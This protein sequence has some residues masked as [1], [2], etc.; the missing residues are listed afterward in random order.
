MSVVFGGGGYGGEYYGGDGGGYYGDGTGDIAPYEPTKQDYLNGIINTVRDFTYNTALGKTPSSSETTISAQT[1]AAIASGLVTPEEA[2]KVA[3]ETMASAAAEAAAYHAPANDS[4]KYGRESS[5]FY[6]S[7]VP[8]DLISI[9]EGVLRGYNYENAPKK[10]EAVH[11]L[12]P[13]LSEYYRTGSETALQKAQD[14]AAQ[15]ANAG[16]TQKEFEG[17]DAFAKAWTFYDAKKPGFGSFAEGIVKPL[18]TAFNVALPIVTTVISG[19]VASGF[20]LSGVAA[21]AV[22]GA[23]SGG[24]NAAIKDQDVLQGALLGGTL[25]AATGAASSAAGSAVSDAIG[26]TAGAVAGSAASGATSAGIKALLLGDNPNTPEDEGDLFKALLKGATTGGVS[27][28]VSQLG[29]EYLGDL[30]DPLKQ[31][32]VSATTAKL[33]GGNA[34]TAFINSVMSSLPQYLRD[35]ASTR[36]I[37]VK[38]Y[39]DTSRGLDL[40]PE[41]DKAFVDQLAELDVEYARQIYQEKTGDELTDKQLRDAFS[42]GNPF[43]AVDKLAATELATTTGSELDKFVKDILKDKVTLTSDDYISLLGM[44]ET[45]AKNALIGRYNTFV[46]DFNTVT[47]EEAQSIWDAAGNT[48]PMTSEEMFTMLAGNQDSADSFAKRNAEFDTEVF[49]GNNYATQEEARAAALAAKEDTGTFN[50]YRWGDRIYKTDQEI[51]YDPYVNKT[52]NSQVEAAIEAARNNKTTYVWGD[53]VFAINQDFAKAQEEINKQPTFT[54]A[55][56]KAQ[57]LL[58]S[59]KPFS[60]KDQGMFT[61]PSGVPGQ[62]GE[63]PFDA[64]DFGELEKFGQNGLALAAVEANKAGKKTFTYSDG[65]TY[66]L[67]D[68][69]A[70]LVSPDQTLAETRRLFEQNNLLKTE[71]QLRAEADF[72]AAFG[73]LAEY[74]PPGSD[75]RNLVA[76]LIGGVGNIVQGATG[77]IN[78][79]ASVK[80]GAEPTVGLS[81]PE[82][83]D[84]RKYGVN[85]SIYDSPEE[86]AAKVKH[87]QELK[88]AGA[89]PVTPSKNLALDKDSSMYKLGEWLETTGVLNSPEAQQQKQVIAD[90]LKDV[91]AYEKPSALAAIVNNGNWLGAAAY[92]LEEL[93]QEGAALAATMAIPGSLAVRALG[94]ATIDSSIDAGKAWQDRYDEARSKGKTEEQAALEG[95]VV[96]GITVATELGPD[97]LADKAMLKVLSKEIGDTAITTAVNYGKG[98]GAALGM[99]FASGYASEYANSALVDLYDTGTMN[100]WDK[101][102][103][104]GT[105]GAFTEMGV[106]GTIIG[107]VDGSRAIGKLYDGTTATVQD[108]LNNNPNLNYATIDRTEP[109]FDIGGN[110][111]SLN[112][113]GTVVDRSLADVDFS[114]TNYVNNLNQLGEAGFTDAAAPDIAFTIT[115][116]PNA[117]T[118]NTQLKNAGLDLGTISEIGNIKFDSA[119]IAPSEVKEQFNKYAYFSPDTQTITSFAGV[120]SD[121]D[122]A[123]AVSD[124]VNKN[125]T[126]AEEV[127]AEAAK[128]GVTLTDEQAKQFEKQGDQ[129]QYLENIMATIQ[130]GLGLA[131]KADVES[132][133][134]NIQFP[135]GVTQAQ[136]EKIIAAA[137]DKIIFPTALIESQV[138]KIV[139]DAVASIKFPDTVSSA[140]VQEIADTVGDIAASDVRIQKLIEGTQPTLTVPIADEA[141]WFARTG[142]YDAKYDLNKDGKLTIAEAGEI[143]V[144]ARTGDLSNLPANSYWRTPQGGLQQAIAEAATP[145]EVR[146]IVNDAISKIDFPE[147]LNEEQAEKLINDAIGDIDFP[148]TLSSSD[149]KGIVDTALKGYATKTDIQ[150]A[151]KGIKFPESVTKDQVNTIVNDAIDGIQFPATLT[152][153]QVGK[154]VGDAIA[155]IEFPD[156]LTEDDVRGIIGSAATKASKAT[157]VYKAID[158]AIANIKFPQGLTKEDV[159]A[160]IKA[161]ADANPGLTLEQVTAAVTTELG[162]LPDYATPDDVTTAIETAVTDLSGQI[163]SLKDAIDSAQS[164]NTTR[165]DN[166]DAAI[167]ALKDAGLTE[168]QVQSVVDASAEGLSTEFK[169]AL[170]AAVTG[171]TEALTTLQTDLETKISGVQSA[172]ETALGDQA[173]NFKDQVDSLMEQGQSYQEATNTALANLGIDI[174]TLGSDVA[175][176]LSDLESSFDTKLS[177][178]ES[179]LGTA[180]QDILNQLSAYEEAGIDRDTALDLAISGVAQDLGTTKEDLLFQIGSSEEALRTEFETGQAALGEQIAGVETRLAEAIAAAE[181][182]GLSRDEAIQSALDTVSADLGT[183]KEALLS[184]LGTTE[185]TLRSELEAGLSGV[186]T[187]L[188]DAIAAAEAAGLSRDEAIQAGL[189]VVAADLGTTKEALLTQLGTTEAALREELTAGL[190]GVETRLQEA[191][192]AAEAAGLSRDEAI[193]AAIDTVATDLGTT[194]TDLLD[195]LGKSEEALRTELTT[196]LAGVETALG[197][198]KQEILDKVAEYEAAGIDRDTALDLAISGVAQ[199]LGKTKEDLLTE[200]GATEQSLLT[201]LSETEAALRGEISDAQQAILDKV[202]EYEAAGI[203]RDE[204][205]NLAIGDVSTQLGRTEESL[206][207]EFEAGQAALGEQVTTGFERVQADLASAEQRIQERAAEYEA[208]GLSRDQ[209]LSQAITDVAAQLDTTAQELEESIFAARTALSEQI[210][211]VQTGL[212]TQINTVADFL[213]KPAQAVTQQDID[214]VNS[215][216]QGTETT[217]DLTYDANRDG[218]IDQADLDILTGIYTRADGEPPEELPGTRWAPTGLYGEIAGL[219]GDLTGQLR[220]ME[221]EQIAREQ[222]AER[223]RQEQAKQAAQQAAQQQKRQQLFGLLQQ[224]GGFTPQMVQVKAPEVAKIGPLYDFSSIFRTPEQEQFFSTPFKYGMYEGGEVT[225]EELLNIVRG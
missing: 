219:R 155:G 125:F 78:G 27:S 90:F 208:A 99:S 65:K 149:V 70:S 198:T 164:G 14:Y 144:A 59:G 179:A 204:A 98:V 221:E 20:G 55:L 124:Y 185:E 95:F 82:V 118:L 210:T 57:E 170:D 142:I 206:R 129:N 75:A 135:E 81:S 162:K 107:T 174:S 188:Q 176:K 146:A 44:S 224:P 147:S 76:S 166:I 96:A 88:D 126:T 64:K 182:A 22:Q 108:L 215:I 121:K 212:Q 214:Y 109:I 101:Y 46:E 87:L 91:P 28:G 29:G 60:Y 85:F 80:I 41:A 209:A 123:K 13:W 11:N 194:K 24:I 42:Q 128:N 117:S 40:L 43:D 156:A 202:A 50:T 3:D 132:A 195:Q 51:P 173:D 163:T 23:I 178:V 200:I 45:E 216:L 115:T 133:I 181:A 32:I 211:G 15:A 207:S 220:R 9:G 31:G 33:L 67:P 62:P 34:E 74:M 66:V 4:W 201:T 114:P 69:F 110:G 180:K 160:E 58:G 25:G 152:E 172:L 190:T 122:L 35:Q 8:E 177:A 203:S 111:V 158:D 49:Y 54:E 120:K 92:I 71:A 141:L 167:Q 130:E 191:I 52:A 73:P 154:I 223:V 93:P 136:V 131:T 83:E 205:L 97:F 138:N 196:G 63:V 79:V 61:T 38:A 187:R 199:D 116:A 168:E 1:K 218:V 222:E 30:P 94:S 112:Q 26:G 18:Q 102:S 175:T 183:T 16:I 89:Q 159:A 21:S 161:F 56:A 171:N 225:E 139:S 189:D 100:N 134:K 47:G 151:I 186:E 86:R 192:A 36:D 103:T 39:N 140:E 157:G 145:A 105:I 6:N 150:N 119:F 68:N 72:N 104:Q 106:S 153:E 113:I 7:G 165:F 12:K 53:K 5:Y 137:I 37:L 213:G 143:K 17:L 148:D 193:T 2:Q 184:Q 217:P 77:L 48:R 19:G 84:A 197:E 127:K 10:Y 169:N